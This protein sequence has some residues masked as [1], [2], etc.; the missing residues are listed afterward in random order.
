[1]VLVLGVA[2]GK[3]SRCV[4]P[5]GVIRNLGLQI[6]GKKSEL[7]SGFAEEKSQ[8]KPLPFSWELLGGVRVVAV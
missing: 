6:S 4:N 5:L 8:E 3:V 1:M 2:A 7:T